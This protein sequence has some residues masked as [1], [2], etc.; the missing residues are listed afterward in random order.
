MLATVVPGAS[1]FR[2]P[3]KTDLDPETALIPL[4]EGQTESLLHA[5]FL[6]APW[7]TFVIWWP[8][9]MYAVDLAA[10]SRVHPYTVMTGI[11]LLV[12]Y[13]TAIRYSPNL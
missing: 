10:Q 1:D 8:G 4:P 5:L 11:T 12:G 3:A 9:M 2:I 7:Y 6:G 13:Y